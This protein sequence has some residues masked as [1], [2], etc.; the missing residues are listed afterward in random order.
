MFQEHVVSF[1]AQ[2][3]ERGRR[4]AA[5]KTGFLTAADHHHRDDDYD[6][7]LHPAGVERVARRLRSSLA[8]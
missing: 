7:P 3:I 4:L 6:A 5:S 1:S 2:I 8:S